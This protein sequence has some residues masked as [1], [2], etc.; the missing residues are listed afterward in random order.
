MASIKKKAYSSK[1]AQKT[2]AKRK[3]GKKKMTPYSRKKK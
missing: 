3:K 1:Q 2:I